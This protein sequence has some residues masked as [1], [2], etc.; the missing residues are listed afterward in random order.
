MPEEQKEKKMFRRESDLKELQEKFNKFIGDLASE[1]ASGENI[2]DIV[3]TMR[4]DKRLPHPFA[5]FISKFRFIIF[6]IVVAL[7]MLVP[8]PMAID[9][10]GTV[11]PASKT[12]MRVPHDGTLK[13]VRFKY[14]EMVKKDDIICEVYNERYGLEK[15]LKGERLKTTEEERVATEKLA[16]DLRIIL[17]RKKGLS[18][19]GLVS[20]TEVDQAQLE[21][22]KAEIA[23]LNVT[24]E[25]KTLKEAI[26]LLESLIQESTIRSQIDGIFMTPNLNE[27]AN[28]FIQKGEKLCEVADLSDFIVEISMKEKDMMTIRE[29]Q[30]VT[31]RFSI[32]PFSSYA[33][34]IFR[35]GYY[36]ADA[37][38]S[39]G[40]VAQPTKDQFF[41][42]TFE[43]KTTKTISAYIKVQDIP[44]DIKYGMA[45]K[46]RATRISNIW[47]ALFPKT[48]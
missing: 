42:I 33:G 28:Q 23:H 1:K 45:A 16:Q 4:K 27:S 40:R 10:V 38:G 35:V 48:M 20:A 31:V 25:I 26:A 43:A 15:G 21:Y 44:K 2:P 5:V 32:H 36:V 3:E 7:V 22:D 18:V 17:E 46:V 39:K 30:R 14:G 34:E 13:D 9:F 12:V 29:G 24:R 47:S 37:I 11:I 8:F 19:K 6:I 41:L